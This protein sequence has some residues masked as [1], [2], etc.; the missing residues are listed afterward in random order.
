M[1][2]TTN[3]KLIKST[4]IIGFAILLSRLLGFVRDILFANLFG[5]NIYAQAFAVAF[6]IPNM[7][8][9]LVGEGATNAAIVPVLSEYRERRSEDEYWEAARVILNLMLVVL[10]VISVIGVIF[11]PVI[12]KMM[13][14]GFISDPEKFRSAVILTRLLVPYIVFLGIIAYSQGVL[15]SLHSFTMPAFA[16]SVLNVTM[17][18]AIIYL[19]PGMGI[20]GL[21][22]G[23]LTGGMIQVLMQMP[24]MWVRGFRLKKNFEIAHPVAQR[25]GRLLLPRL[26]GSGVYQLS[27]LVD[28][29]LASFGSVVGAGGV[30]AL[31]Y[32]N[33]LIQLPLAIFGIS[34]ATA[35]LPKMSREAA[36]NDINKLKDTV[37]FSLQIVAIVMLP[38]SFGLLVLAEPIVRVLFQRGEFTSYSTMITTSALFFYTFGLF[39]YSGIK[40]LVN[41]YFSL[42]DTRTPVKTAFLALLVN[43]VLN[44]ALMWPLKIGGLALATSIAAT[45]NFVMLYMMLEKRIGKMKTAE[46]VDSLVRICAASLVMAAVTFVMRVMLLGGD[47]SGMRGVYNIVLIIAVSVTVFLV[48][49]Y[50]AKVEGVRRAWAEVAVR[51][52]RVHSA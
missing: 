41:A 10:A 36:A 24:S 9:D 26:V 40:I 3:R 7:L 30:A 16:S 37:I 1:T 31:Y 29:V 11:A 22:V 32:S 45:Y 42:G 49:A 18:I 46:F 39:A 4:G 34:L 8:R 15:N 14:P 44:L 38:A 21:V 43:L 20:Y 48:S 52:R 35:A 17:I 25:V 27:V 28:T 2:M 51:V 47:V 13:A 6:R 5:T 50:F 23:V 33:R 19:C 12:V